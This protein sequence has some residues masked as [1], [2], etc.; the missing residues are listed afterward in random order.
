MID[1]KKI[2]IF[3]GSGSLGNAFID[4]YLEKN[5][6]VNYSRDECKHWKMGLK[7]KS[8]KLRFIIGDVRD[9]NRVENSLIRE[10]PSLIIIAAALK[11]IDRCEYAVNECFMTNFMGPNNIINAVEKNIAVLTN[12][13]TVVYI[14]TDKATSPVNT[15]G[16][17]KEL[18][19]KSMIAASYHIPK[20]KFI[21]VKYGNVLN[22]RGSIIPILHKQGDDPNVKEFVLTHPE[23]TRFVMTLSQSVDLIEHAIFNAESGDVVIPTLVSMKVKDLLEIFSEKYNKPVSTGKLRPGEKLLES[24]INETQS[25]SMIKGDNYY[26]IKPPY[27]NICIPEQAMDY[28]SRLNPLSKIELKKYLDNLGLL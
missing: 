21:T 27:K 24:L 20:I 7:Y 26:Y 1:N 14:N 5:I 25:M 22:S 6:I 16:L 28:N 18:A 9:Y 10:N 23:A 3:G 19:S 13:E 2:L 15:Y 11:H 12:L 17:A 8:D 4:R